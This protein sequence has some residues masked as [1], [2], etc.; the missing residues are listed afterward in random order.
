MFIKRNIILLFIVILLHNHLLAINGYGLYFKS[1]NYPANERTSLILNNNIPFKI[2]ESLTIEFNMFIREQARFGFILN[3][4]MDN[5]KEHSLI[6]SADENDIFYPA[7]THDGVIDAIAPR[8]KTN[9][10][11]PVSIKIDKGSN[12]IDIH[13][14]STSLKIKYPLKELKSLLPIFGSANQADVAPFNIKDVLVKQN[15]KPIKYWKLYRHNGDLCLDELDRTPAIAQH[16]SWLID[17]HL[18]WQKI[19]TENVEGE[20]N[21]AFNAKEAHFFLKDHKQ[22]RIIDGNTGK[23]IKTYKQG[24]NL[25]SQFQ[26]HLLF[27][28]LTN[29]LY[30]YSI[31]DKSSVYFSFD[32]KK[33]IGTKKLIGSPRFNNHATAF[34]SKDSSFY[35]VGGYGFYKY[36]NNLFRMDVNSGKINQMDY[37]PRISP[38][39]A[40]AACMVDDIIYIFGGIGN[41]AG[42]QEFDHHGYFDLQ[43]INP[44]TETSQLLWKCC[45]RRLVNTIMASSMYYNPS[46]S[47]FY[48]ASMN[49]GGTLWKISMKDSVW[50]EVSHPIHNDIIY[51]DIEF[52]LYHS[53][54]YQKFYLMID[55]ISSSNVHHLSLYSIDMP[56][57]SANEIKQT[58]EEK[59]ATNKYVYIIG[60]GL[61]VVI[62]IAILLLRKKETFGASPVAVK[63]IENNSLDTESEANTTAEGNKGPAIKYFNRE[64]ACISLLGTFNVRDKEGND[65]THLF[66]PKLKGLL[67][68]IILYTEKQK[69]G[70]L[71]KNVL[72]TIWPDKE[73]N[74]AKN[75]L[76]VNL[77]KLRVLL[78][79][80]GDIEIINESGFLRIDWHEDVC[81]DYRSAIAY[82]KEYTEQ[83]INDKEFIDRIIEI[84]LWG[85]LLRNTHYE[86]LDEFKEFYSSLS[87]D[88]L[89]NLLLQK[90]SNQEMTLRI[91]DI[92]FLHDPLNE[93]ALTAK[94]SILFKKGKKGLAMNAYNRFC[95]EYKKSLGEEY[96][97]PIADLIK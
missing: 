47:S 40:S 48:A 31:I 54:K 86:W 77:R 10:W 59:A 80:I 29:H 12:M 67:I 21:V 42:R 22:I 44:Q 82:C 84:L 65:I 76:N 70:I 60:V 68:L 37:R 61:V 17:N 69:N 5:Q 97:T 56:L 63:E 91:A 74:S 27:D 79:D 66:T 90:T 55:K 46:D 57:L 9:C 83:S 71:T 72:E 25:S 18:V 78:E 8:I 75:N 32:E 95:E 23:L 33:W 6:L 94:C 93:E 92:I 43:M 2:K 11:I 41:Q 52:D 4:Q 85:P 34:N 26:G 24:N 7:Y 88:L 3:L 13:L 96:Q 50:T 87:I 39:S 89:T 64:K 15:E 45:N 49:K 51:Q 62:G 30:S 81:C 36:R 73:E 35:F 38:R 16:P 58:F 20:F 14:D 19:Y 53:P 1:Y 28:T